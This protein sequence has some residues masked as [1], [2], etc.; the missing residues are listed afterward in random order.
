[1]K[2]RIL[3]ITAVLSVAAGLLGMSQSAQAA[4]YFSATGSMGANRLNAAAAPLPD[5]RVLVAG[6]YTGSSVLSSAEIYDPVTGTFTPTGSMNLERRLA[7]AAP[8]PDGRVLV[9]GGYNGIGNPTISAEIYDPA[10]GTFDFTGPMWVARA[11]TAAAALPDGRVIVAG[12]VTSSVLL[13]AVEVYDPSTGNFTPSGNLSQN[14][15]SP[16]AAT[17][18]NGRVLVAGGFS[19]AAALSSAEIYN[20]AS[21][22]STPTGSMS[23]ARRDAAAAVRPDGRVLVV[24][25]RDLGNL[26]TV[27]IYDPSSGTFAGTASMSTPRTGPV[28]SPLPNGRTLV[29]GGVLT[30]AP[31]SSAILYNTDAEAR[32]TDAEFGQQVVGEP[33]TSL[34][35]T[36]TNRGSNR[37]TIS[38]P[39]AISG[40]NPGDFAVT[41][42]RC[43]GQVLEFGNS[44]RIYVVAT[45]SAAG[46]RTGSLTVPSNSSP[47]IEADLIV[48]GA[49]SPVGPTGGTGPT[50][51]TGETGTSG[52][53]GN[54]GPSGPTGGGGPTGPKGPQGSRGPRGPAATVSFAPRAFRGLRPGQSIVAKVACPEGSGGC[55]LFRTDAIWRGPTRSKSL[56]VTA[57]GRVRAGR[58][59]R[60]RVTLPAGLAHRL[61][62]RKYHGRLADTVGARTGNDRTTLTRH[63][64]TIG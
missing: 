60:I 10:T 4:P 38:G 9:V 7:S 23:Q 36:I 47:S 46:L 28:A 45:P 42:N 22:T 51:T 19:G 49:E 52:P 14:R 12:G 37:L 31:V 41:Q 61:A 11:G 40:T 5:G 63:L 26:S 39:P 43:S 6:G 21:G 8:L 35:V 59:A 24:G 17:L 20:P 13:G 15:L 16:V 27:E 54:S 33:T 34:P 50:G 48:E 44:C 62:A 56:R 30:G 2:R 53:T 1:V 25:G 64:L 18:P 3:L 55:D 29:A 57:P 32:A 58:K